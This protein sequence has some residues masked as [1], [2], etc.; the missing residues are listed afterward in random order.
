[1]PKASKESVNYSKGMPHSHCG[2]LK[3]DDPYMCRHFIGTEPHKDGR[4]KVVE[5]TIGAGM[6]CKLYAK[7]T[8]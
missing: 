7:T 2:P 1:M 4:C 5:G 6:W 8:A 3:I